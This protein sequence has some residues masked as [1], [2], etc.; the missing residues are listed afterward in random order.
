MLLKVVATGDGRLLAGD[1]ARLRKG[2][3]DGKFAVRPGDGSPRASGVE[4]KLLADE[5]RVGCLEVRLRRGISYQG[6]ETGVTDCD[7]LS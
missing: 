4:V 2:L 6:L 7:L 5:R 3:F 1:T